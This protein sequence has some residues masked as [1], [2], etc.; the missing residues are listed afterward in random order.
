MK[1]CLAL[2]LGMLL[3]FGFAAMAQVATGN[4]SETGNPR[5]D[6]IDAQNFHGQRTVEGCVVQQGSDYLVVPKHGRPLALTSSAT[7]DLGQNVGHEIKVSGRESIA[8]GSASE[9]A[10][11]AV[12]AQHIEVMAPSCPPNWNRKWFSRNSNSSI[13]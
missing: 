7:T 8:G 6:V 4:A 10:N 1:N 2:C 11:Y 9:E 5:T 13:K 12:A 3:L